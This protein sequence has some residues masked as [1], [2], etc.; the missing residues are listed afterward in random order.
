MEDEVKQLKELG[1]EFMRSNPPG[2]PDF[3]KAIAAYTKALAIDKS[4]HTVFTNRS[5]AFFKLCKYD[6]ALADAERAIEASPNWPKGYLRKC[7]A[8]NALKRNRDAQQAAQQGFILMHSMS[9][10]REFVNQ[11]LK[12]CDEIYS[13][14]KLGELLPRGPAQLYKVMLI[15]S[16][17]NGGQV[18]PAGLKVVSDVYWK[19]LFYCIASL[20][21]PELTPPNDAIKQYFVQILDEFKQIMALFGHDTDHTIMKWALFVGETINDYQSLMQTKTSSVEAT[22]HFVKFL[23]S[24]LHVTLYDIARPLLLLIIT[25]ISTQMYSFNSANTGHYSICHMMFMCLPLFDSAVLNGPEYVNHH[26]NMLVGLIDSYNRTSTN[27]S[28]NQCS[29]LE[30]HCK[31][32]ELL[33]PQFASRYPT[34]YQQFRE[35]Y[36]NVIG[37]AKTAM[38]SLNTGKTISFTSS[39][40]YSSDQAMQ[41]MKVILQ[42]PKEFLTICDAEEMIGLSGKYM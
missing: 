36:E 5:L 25:V 4:C 41:Q 21:S 32:L 38:F 42:K 6:E 23:N 1:N 18:I 17:Q 24:N 40:S 34:N 22:E 19:I 31:K 13:E 9:F 8:L 28:H 10:C 27:L 29:V 26:V 11:W 35:H 16:K 7:L 20:A 15:V 30:G 37:I 14:D 39:P 3:D 12:A 33:L 2:P